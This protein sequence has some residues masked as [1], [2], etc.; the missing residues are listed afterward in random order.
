M[1]GAA[2][3]ASIPSILV[4]GNFR[5]DALNAFLKNVCENIGV[6]IPFSL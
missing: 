5:I 2:E 1:N 3:V 6:N 4:S